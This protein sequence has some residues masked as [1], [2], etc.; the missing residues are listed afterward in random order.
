MM[1]NYLITLLIVL[2]LSAT[3]SALSPSIEV[4]C[5]YQLTEG[6][7]AE[8][9]EMQNECAEFNLTEEKCVPLLKAWDKTV[10]WYAEEMEDYVF[11][12]EVARFIKGVS[13]I[14]GVAFALI[15]WYLVSRKKTAKKKKRR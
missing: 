7:E 11:D 10:K 6:W 12:K 1:K 3:V 9:E 15:I 4:E 13:I 2:M 8:N 14:G 5:C